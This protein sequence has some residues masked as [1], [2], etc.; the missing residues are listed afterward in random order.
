MRHETSLHRIRITLRCYGEGR[1]S[2]RHTSRLWG[3]HQVHG[4]RRRRLRHMAI[5]AVLQELIFL[6]RYSWGVH[7]NGSTMIRRQHSHCRRVSLTVKRTAINHSRHLHWHSISMILSSCLDF[8]SLL[9]CVLKW[10]ASMLHVHGDLMNICRQRSQQPSSFHGAVRF[11]N[12]SLVFALHEYK[13]GESPTGRERSLSDATALLECFCV[14]WSRVLRG[15]NFRQK[16][17]RGE[18][19][20]WTISGRCH[21]SPKFFLRKLRKLWGELTSLG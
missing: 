7:G 5:Q 4:L 17:N 19:F 15:R 8:L 3:R 18:H 11:M 1:R 20:L 13:D 10:V 2:R 14:C 6:R 21:V 12:Q 9:T 16:S